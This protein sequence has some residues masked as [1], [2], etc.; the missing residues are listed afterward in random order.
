MA[1][2]EDIKKAILAVAG[3]PDSG[4]VADF[5]D[6]WAEAIVGLD[7]P[8]PFIAD[9]RDGDGDGIVQ[10]GTP[11]ARPAKETRVTKPEATR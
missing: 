6:K 9:A 3:N 10:E 1:T 5:A 7:A 8:V 4:I 11:F 2:K